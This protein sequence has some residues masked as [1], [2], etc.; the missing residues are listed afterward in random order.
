LHSATAEIG[1]ATA[2]LFPKLSLNGNLGTA[3]A[4]PGLLGTRT[5]SWSIG[6][7]A[8]WSIFDGGAL[9]PI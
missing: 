3:A 6:P 1:V 5:S 7:Q 2:D 9:P 8:S 4:R